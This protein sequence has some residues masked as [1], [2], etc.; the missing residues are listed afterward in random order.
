MQSIV[1]TLG[2]DADVESLVELLREHYPMHEAFDT[3]LERH[4][5]DSFDWRL[6]RNNRV[7]GWDNPDGSERKK[8]EG[9]FFIRNKKTSDSVCEYPI[10][11]IPRFSKDVVHRI[12]RRILDDLLD[13]R[14]LMPV[15]TVAVRSRQ[16]NI[17]NKENKTVAVVRMEIHVLTGDMD[18]AFHAGR[19]IVSP[20]KGYQKIFMQLRRYIAEKLRLPCEQIALLDEILATIGKAPDPSVYAGVCKLNDSLNTWEAARK[21]LRHLFRVMRANEPGLRDAVDTEFL[22]DYR[23]AVRRT[24]SLLSQIKHVFPARRLAYFKREFYWLGQVTGPLRDLDVYLL[25]FDAYRQALP[26]AMQEHIASFHVFLKRHRKFEHDRLC[27]KFESKRYQQLIKEWCDML[28]KENIQSH[29]AWSQTVAS[30][31]TI[32]ANKPIRQV[33]GKRIVKLYKRILQEGSSITPESRDEDL[34]ELRKTCKKFRYLVEFFHVFYPENVVR[35][36]LKTLKQLQDHLGE[37]QDLCVQTVQLS[38]FAEQMRQEKL[39]D[40]KTIMAMGVLVEKLNVRK[41]AIRTEFEHCFRTFAQPDNRVAFM[42]TFSLQN[43]FRGRTV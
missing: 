28:D 4:Y 26:K 8:N 34:H 35:D 41:A 17:L 40:T 11:R 33:A 29:R 39:A 9:V 25:T 36:L 20:V 1:Y 7:C 16:F 23:V 42:K 32:N 30:L 43:Q 31:E 13:I 3:R 10:D 27:R 12:C 14:A 22:H 21:L 15:V 38:D 18:K 24:R 19:L 37:F 5:L 6:Y 2:Q